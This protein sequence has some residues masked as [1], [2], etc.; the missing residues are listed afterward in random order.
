MRLRKILWILPLLMT[1]LA[2]SCS[3]TPQ[4]GVPEI[5]EGRSVCAECGMIID[6]V[7]F[8]AAL[9]LN[10]GTPKVFDDIG[11]LLSWVEYQEA[12]GLMWVFDW[13]TRQAVPADQAF[14]V[15]NSHHLTPMG[16]GVAAFSKY[17]AASEHVNESGSDVM[18]WSDLGEAF[19]NGALGISNHME[20]MSTAT[21]QSEEIEIE[22]EDH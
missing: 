13:D 2:F 7:T 8:A 22:H 12:T 3:T 16:W 21:E 4:E 10:D 9:R 19:H 18:T 17:E 1:S 20:D 5:L 14:Y 15:F 11:G 6:D